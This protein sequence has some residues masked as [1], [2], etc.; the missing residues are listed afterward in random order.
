MP[1]P[2][3]N[4]QQSQQRARAVVAAQQRPSQ[5]EQNDAAS[6]AIV[7]VTREIDNRMAIVEASAAAGIRPERLKLVALTA[8]TRNP[9]LLRCD[10]VSVAR[11]IVEAGQL[12]LEPTGLLGGAYLV[13]RAG[14]A[15]LLVGYK[16]LVM[17]AKRS[18]EVSRVEARVVRQKDVF[19]YSYGLDPRLEHRP[20][21]ELDPGPY[22][23]AYAVIHYRDGTRQFDVMS[24]AEI[25]VIRGRSAAGQSGPWVT[26]E[27]EMWKK[28]VLR[29]ALKL[30]PLTVQVAQQLDELDPEVSEPHAGG[31]SSDG[32]EAALRR[33][34]QA[35]LEREYGGAQGASSGAGEVEG[36]ATELPTTQGASGGTAG[37]QAPAAE[38]AH[39]A[40]RAAA[41]AQQGGGPSPTVQAPAGPTPAGAPAAARGGPP[42]RVSE[43][44]GA[45]CGAEW[46]QMQAGP[47][48]LPAGHTASEWTDA[49][50]E[51]QKPQASHQQADGQV[52]TVPKEAAQ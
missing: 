3:R 45:T 42:E 40:P 1:A 37:A 26:D 50:G 13:P 21:P 2:N 31:A 28:T 39:E 44:L 9:D 5:A 36:Q 48:V 12:G 46:P 41:E 29:R 25:E 49:N 18:G 27:A 6:R 30:A 20:S 14:K 34:L 33:R 8:F 51:K 43:V 16:G 52:F 11:A 7:A 15:T 23:H 32:H 38:G 47:C 17:L 4:Q 24:R 35:A 19:E 22:T 10:P